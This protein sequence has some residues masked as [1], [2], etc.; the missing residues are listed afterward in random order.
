MVISLNRFTHPLLVLILMLTIFR[1]D[2]QVNTS[3]NKLAELKWDLYGPWSILHFCPSIRLSLH[4][5]SR[6]TQ[7][8]KIMV[9]RITEVVNSNIA[10]IMRLVFFENWSA[11]ER[12]RNFSE[13]MKMPSERFFFPF[14]AERGVNK[15]L[16]R[17]GIS[18]KYRLLI[19]DL[20]I[21]Q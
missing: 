9:W 18:F 19:T 3:L 17:A 7:E 14:I 5:H 20:Q 11:C 15:K 21:S 4:H 6:P 10:P 13:Q 2:N 8:L 12:N 16:T 1:H